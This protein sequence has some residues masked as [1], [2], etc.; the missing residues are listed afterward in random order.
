[1]IKQ[2]MFVL[3]ILMTILSYIV[4][5]KCNI[6]VGFD[7]VVIGIM[8]GTG[9]GMIGVSTLISDLVDISNGCFKGD[10]SDD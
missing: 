5:L 3:N 7:I 9:F 10:K 6:I 4:L 8:L 1:M 2:I